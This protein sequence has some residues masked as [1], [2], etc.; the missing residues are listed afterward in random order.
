MSTLISSETA[1]EADDEG[2][3]VDALHDL[4][5]L[6]GITLVLEPLL[7][8]ILLYEIDELILE[9]HS[10]VPDFLIGHIED[11]LPHL[12]IALILIEILIEFLLIEFLP[13]R[14]SP[15]RHVHTVGDISD[16]RLLGSVTLPDA[17]EHL[18]GD[19]TMEPANAVGFLASVESEDAHRESFVGVGVL[20]AHVHKVRPR[21]AET[22]GELTHILT[23]ECLLEIVVTG[24]D[25]SVNSI[26]RRCTHEFESH[27]EGEVVIVDIVDE[28][29]EV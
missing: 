7:L 13:L 16:V 21:D 14:C 22:S 4:D 8:E 28:A 5:H 24:G 27:I 10:H 2:V 1:S 25:G 29:L 23:E 3:G 12:V 17:G 9:S 18:L 26:E 20:A 15:C 6:S 11:V 19:L